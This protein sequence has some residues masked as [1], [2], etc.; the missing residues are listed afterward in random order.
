MQSAIVNIGQLATLSGPAR[1]RKGREME[2]LGLIER[3]AV[4]FRDGL[5]EAV[6]PQRELAPSI[7]EDAE[8]ID[9]G[10]RLV[11]PGFVDAHTHA[12]FAGNRANEFEARSQGATYQQ[13][14]EAGGGILST[15]RSTRAATEDELWAE[16][17]KHLQWMLE[18]GTTT[19]EVKSGY[20]LDLE[21][22]LKMLRVARRL[23]PQR[24]VTTF[25]GAHAV[26][27]EVSQP[28]YL[29]QVVAMLP[30]VDQ[31]A[32]ACDIFVENG[33]FTPADAHR[34]FG[35]TSLRRRLHVDQFGDHGGA[36]LAAELGASTADHL[37]HTGPAGIAALAAAGVVPVLLPASVFL[38]GLTKYP[39]ARGMIDAGL[40]VVLATDFNP[41]SSP[42]PSMA[43]VTSLACTQMHMSPGE[44][45]SAAT[46]NAAHALGVGEEVGSL[47]AGKRA[48]LVV[49]DADDYRELPYWAGRNTVRQVFIGG[50]RVLPR[51]KML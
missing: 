46:I 15:V 16:S 20:G 34:L 3:A 9:A 47:E 17:Q 24:V 18:G 13:I 48:D 4:L 7:D 44:A 36:A 45:L 29:E 10:G 8:L 27:P 26:P 1:G 32:D 39:D 21:T 41:G 35:S 50:K 43:M 11:T 42:C 5:I 31:R 23:G 33:Y 19:V 2:D 25:L 12:V 40:P 30:V 38:L 22:E 51:D 28:E 37:E 49:H 14:K 6:G